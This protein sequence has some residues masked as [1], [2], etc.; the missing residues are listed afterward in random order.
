MNAEFAGTSGRL[1]GGANGGHGASSVPMSAAAATG[2]A[3]G[4]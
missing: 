2:R 1:D 3:T 4:A